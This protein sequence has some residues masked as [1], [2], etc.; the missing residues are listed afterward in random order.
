MEESLIANLDILRNEKSGVSWIGTA[1]T[2]E[3]AHARILKDIAS[4]VENYIIFNSTTGDRISV[5]S[6]R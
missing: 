4:G 3:D 2:L 5:E 1:S 6:R